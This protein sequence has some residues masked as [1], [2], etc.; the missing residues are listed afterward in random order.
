MPLFLALAESAIQLVPDGTIIFHIF[1]IIV[2]IAVLNRTLFKPINQILAEREAQTEGSLS[3]AQSVIRRVRQ[4]V[5]E[6]EQ[7]LREA[8]NEG[9]QL[10]EKQRLESLREREEKIRGLKEEIT[11]WS[12]Q[13]KTQLREEVQK[14]HASLTQNSRELANEIATRILERPVHQ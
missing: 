13:Q 14:T 10:M 8:R 4:L 9:Y 11:E 1:L 2:M 6:Y 5:H 3:E 7:R 12:E